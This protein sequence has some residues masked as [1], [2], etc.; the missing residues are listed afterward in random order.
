MTKRSSVVFGLVLIFLGVQTFFYR[1]FLPIFGL[2]T[3]NGRLW[4][5]FVANIGILLVLIPFL[6]RDH[7][8]LGALFIPG[9]PI[10]TTSGM[11]LL[12][13]ITDWWGMWQYMW[14]LV[15]L[16]FALG[17]VVAAAWSRIVWFLIPALIVGVN[18]VMFLF[19]AVTGL[20]QVW[21]GLWPVELLAIGL[22]LLLVN[23]WVQSKGLFTAGMVLS[24]L[25][26]FGFALMALV[27]SG[28]VSIVAALILVS[29]GLVLLGRNALPQLSG[30]ESGTNEKLADTYSK[31]DVIRIKEAV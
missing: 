7:R 16:S 29:A 12:A 25:A 21:A 1:A 27:L 3:G 13:S 5:L 15:V 4:P 10:V 24:V 9:L 18:G 8:G 30:G 2:E 19:C 17:F 14:P 6:A 26:G 20:W 31:E 23:I 22:S 11:L 28:W